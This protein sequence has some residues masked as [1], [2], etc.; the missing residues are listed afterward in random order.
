[1][2]TNLL[3]N[4]FDGAKNAGI[5]FIREYDMP[6]YYLGEEIG[7]RRVDFLIEGRISVELKALVQLEKVHLPKQ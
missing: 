1:L 2:G 3:A 7:R 4:A 5:E 6:I